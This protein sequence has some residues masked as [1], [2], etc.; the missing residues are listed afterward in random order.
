LPKL[1]GEVRE[2]VLFKL[3]LCKIYDGLVIH[4]FAREL[5]SETSVK[6]IMGLYV[7]MANN[8]SVDFGKSMFTY[9]SGK[10]PGG[11]E[12]L[13]WIVSMCLKIKN[14]YFFD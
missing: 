1:E 12:H 9:F 3:C 13:Q 2:N 14:T 10:V 5:H 8:D 11:P 7:S 4:E 6:F